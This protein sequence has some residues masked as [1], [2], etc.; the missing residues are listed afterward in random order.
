MRSRK[1]GLQPQALLNSPPPG[2]LT[3]PIPGRSSLDILDVQIL[4]SLISDLI[5]PT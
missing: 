2:A 4:Y 3:L 5:T 1:F